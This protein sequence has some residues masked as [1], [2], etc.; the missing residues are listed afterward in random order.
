M[1][2]GQQWTG[3]TFPTGAIF[4]TGTVHIGP[5]STA[6]CTGAFINIDEGLNINPATNQPSIFFGCT[7]LLHTDGG[8]NLF[9]GY[10]AGNSSAAPQNMGVGHASGRNLT[11][12]T[13][14]VFLGYLSGEN[15][16]SGSFNVFTGSYAGNFL[17]TGSHNV[18]TGSYAG[19]FLSTGSHNVFTGS[20]AGNQV[21]TGSYNLLSGSHAGNN[22]TTGSQ[23]VF[24]GYTAGVGT[25]DKY[26][27]V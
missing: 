19:N 16:T 23:N 11:T 9:L 22:L 4:R 1:V 25:I 3:S 7:K 24:L 21:T 13:D 8:S 10:L 6:S 2:R 15:V 17:S 26:N 5:S 18:L 20:Y 12:G 27:N 14:N